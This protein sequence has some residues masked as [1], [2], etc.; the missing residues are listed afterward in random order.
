MFYGWIVDIF[1]LYPSTFPSASSTT[2]CVLSVVLRLISTLLF[3]LP[4][5]LWLKCWNQILCGSFVAISRDTS[6]DGE[7]ES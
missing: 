1:I 5:R 2:Y 7:E 6:A 3:L 4:F